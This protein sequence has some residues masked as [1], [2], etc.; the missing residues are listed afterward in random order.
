[1]NGGLLRRVESIDLEECLPI[2]CRGTM[3]DAALR[4][5]A[6]WNSTDQH[7]YVV[8]NNIDG[9]ALRHAPEQAVLA[10]L[11]ACAR[12]HVLAT[13]DHLHAPALFD[14]RVNH[15]FRWLWHHVPTFDAML[16]ETLKI[17]PVLASC[18]RDA[19]HRSAGV[20]LRT[21]GHNSREV[22]A[23]VVYSYLDGMMRM[24]ILLQSVTL[25]TL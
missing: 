25:V 7:V 2:V 18:K 8:I 17:A 5:M 15:E 22:R 3:T 24:I 14:K 6:Q 12:V 1:M 20:V 16:A 10:S 21:L 23:C 4:E 19:T 9:E 11:A 13:V